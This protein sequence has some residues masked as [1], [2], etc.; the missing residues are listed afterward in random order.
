M[1]MGNRKIHY[2]QLPSRIPLV[3]TIASYMAMDYYDCPDILRGIIYLVLFL[4][5]AACIIDVIKSEPTKVKWD[6]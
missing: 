6:S 2:S 5:W 1:S 4:A 3:G